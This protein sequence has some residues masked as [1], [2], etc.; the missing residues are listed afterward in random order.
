MPQLT[1]CLQSPTGNWLA[2]DSGTGQLSA[3]AKTVDE[4]LRFK[5]QDKDDQVDQSDTNTD[6]YVFLCVKP[7]DNSVDSK[8]LSENNDY[9]FASDSLPTFFQFDN[10]GFDPST[11]IQSYV[12]YNSNTSNAWYVDN[13]NMITT[14]SGNANQNIDNNYFGFVVHL[15]A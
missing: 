3:N 2:I 6:K 11:V 4:A 12:C 9:I 7:G 15:L 10:A 5:L 1:F 14:N 13:N 8:Y